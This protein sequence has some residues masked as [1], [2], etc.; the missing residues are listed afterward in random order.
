MSISNKT[1]ELDYYHR[2]ITND[3][4]NK[5]DGWEIPA[6]R[7]GALVVPL[8]M[9]YRPIAEPISM[10]MGGIRIVTHIVGSAKAWQQG[11]FWKLASESSQAGLAIV[12][13]ASCFVQFRWGAFMT[14][15]ADILQNLV[16]I[17]H[18]YRERKF[19]LM[20]EDLLQL[21]GNSFYIAIFAY[22]SLEIV[23]ASMA[24][25]ILINLYQARKEWNENK[26]PEALVKLFVA[27]VRLYECKQNWTI[28]QS[29]KALVAQLSTR[30][31]KTQTTD[32]LASNQPPRKIE[33][34]KS[35][36]TNETT[37]RNNQQVEFNNKNE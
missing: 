12:S 36:S 1:C 6:Q 27:S 30:P 5:K 7:I 16:S 19:D 32:N 24:F 18:H 9:L 15:S 31:T 20:F 33:P 37:N 29:Q 8:M 34:L 4:P 23:I 13:F 10:G 22:S 35:I 11:A 3:L 21:A 26:T 17:S 14:T 2:Q 25:Q 28:L